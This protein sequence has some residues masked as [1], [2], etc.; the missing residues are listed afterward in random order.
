MTI[1]IIHWKA[2]FIYWVGLLNRCKRTICYILQNT[3]TKT[4]KKICYHRT[5]MTEEKSWVQWISWNTE[6]TDSEKKFCSKNCS[7]RN[8]LFH[9]QCFSNHLFLYIQVCVIYVYFRICLIKW[10]LIYFLKWIFY[11]VETFK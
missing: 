2:E 3:S 7:I 1:F 10:L 5:R 4:Y 9:S 11:T 6:K 8:I